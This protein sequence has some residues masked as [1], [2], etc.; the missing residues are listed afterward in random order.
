MDAEDRLAERIALERKT[1]GWSYETLAAA[2]S[3]AGC[4]INGSAIYRIEKGNPRRRV[5]VNELAALAQLWA[6]PVER[7]IQ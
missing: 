1:R 5:T 4:S 3:E 7:L 2:M 6:I